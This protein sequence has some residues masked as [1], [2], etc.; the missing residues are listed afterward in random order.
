MHAYII[1]TRKGKAFQETRRGRENSFANDRL[2]KK[3]KL[4][5]ERRL[6]REQGGLTNLP[7]VLICSVMQSY[8]D[9]RIFLKG[10]RVEIRERKKKDKTKRRTRRL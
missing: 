10:M 5:T 3:K 6:A 1:D 4:L 8:G 7:L 2:I 9:N